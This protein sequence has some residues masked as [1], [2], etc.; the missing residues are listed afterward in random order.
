MKFILLPATEDKPSEWVNLS[1]VDRVVVYL[2][3]GEQ[4]FRVMVCFSNTLTEVY[5]GDR[6]KVLIQTLSTNSCVI[7][8]EK[9]AHEEVQEMLL[10][11]DED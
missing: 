1:N 8:V 7:P 5:R 4:D 11:I 9:L 6:A 10:D 2:P 3:D